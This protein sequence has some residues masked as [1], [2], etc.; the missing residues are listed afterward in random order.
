MQVRDRMTTPP[1][2]VSA[3]AGFHRA[4]RVMQERALRRLPVIDAT[5]R[6]VGMVTER[7]LQLAASHYVQN[8]V[9]IEAIMTRSVVTTTADAPIGD[10]AALMVANKIGGL[11]VVDENQQ[12][13]G[14]ITESD[15]FKLFVE[16]IQT[17]AIPSLPPASERSIES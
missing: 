11:P 15:I 13:I 1:V 6:L 12:V 16:L 14:I 2:T 3:D 5:G 8:S 7:D 4:L 9:E 17:G 10:A